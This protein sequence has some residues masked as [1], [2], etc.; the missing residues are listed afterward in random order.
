MRKAGL[1]CHKVGS[2]SAQCIQSESTFLVTNSSISPTR[3]KVDNPV[4]QLCPI[5]ASLAL[6][7]PLVLPRI[8]SSAIFCRVDRHT[9]CPPVVARLLL[10]FDLGR[11]DDRPGRVSDQPVRERIWGWGWGWGSLGSG[12]IGRLGSLRVTREVEL[13]QT[14]DVDLR[15][16]RLLSR[17]V[18]LQDDF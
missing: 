13:R 11:T 12:L 6:R 4:Q 10:R 5:R 14:Q 17:D 1:N 8:V 15:D 18:R 16:H 2:L 7:A 9:L 3:L